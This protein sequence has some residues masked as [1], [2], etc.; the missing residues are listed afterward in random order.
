MK[1]L[2][3]C[4]LFESNPLNNELQEIELA[5]AQIQVLSTRYTEAMEKSTGL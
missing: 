2:R 5:S 3:G 1:I 4:F